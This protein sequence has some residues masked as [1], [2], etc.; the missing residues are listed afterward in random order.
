MP[1]TD[2]DVMI[3]LGPLRVISQD[4]EGPASPEGHNLGKVNKIRITFK[5]QKC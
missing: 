1:I 5:R 3:G 4:W 2:E